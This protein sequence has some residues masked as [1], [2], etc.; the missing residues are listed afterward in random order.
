[1]KSH[2]LLLPVL[3]FNTVPFFRELWEGKRPG[4]KDAIL[5]FGFDE[6]SLKGG[7]VER[8]SFPLL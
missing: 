1:M 2:E 8:T 5:T 3:I 6:V 7:L 4:T